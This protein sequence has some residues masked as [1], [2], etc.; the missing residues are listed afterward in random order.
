[1]IHN[2]EEQVIEYE[3]ATFEFLGTPIAFFP[4]FFHPDPTVKRKS[5]FLVPSVGFS[6]DLG[7]SVTLP[8]F[9]VIAPNADIT[10]TP[11]AY[12]RQGLLLDGEWRHRTEHG[13]YFVSAGGIL[14]A[15][16]TQFTKPGN[17]N[18]RGYVSSGGQFQLGSQ[19]VFGWNGA[20]VTDDSFLRKYEIN[21]DS[22][23]VSETYLV[24]QGDRNYFDAR[25]QHFRDLSRAGDSPGQPLIHPVVDH[26]VIFGHAVFGGEL[27]IDTNIT[28]LTRDVGPD[29][30]RAS[31]D[32]HWS[33]TFTD[34]FGQQFTPFFSVR[35][36]V[37]QVNAVLD[38]VTAIAG[39][40]ETITRGMA[41]AGFEY[42]YPFISLHSWGQQILEPIVQIIIR[43][44]EQNAGRI[45]NEDA[46]SLVFDDT[47]LFDRNKFSGYDRIEGGS[48]ANIGVRYTLQT[49][50]G[51]HARVVVGQ[52]FQLGGRNPFA[53]G[54]GLDSAR[55]DFVGGIY[56]E[57]TN[58]LGLYSQFRVDSDSYQVN[59]QEFG[60]RVNHNGGNA[61]ISYMRVRDETGVG[62]NREEVLGS[63]LVPVLPEWNLFGS[64]RY[65]IAG[66]Q[67]ISRSLG[68]GYVCDCFSASIE[69]K[70]SFYANRDIQPNRS[71]MFRFFFKS[72]GG[73]QVGSSILDNK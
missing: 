70:E 50:N 56:L 63:A 30:T 71:V 40:R 21:S 67:N 4:Y 45:S 7:A 2:Q 27:G 65:D 37:S 72:L 16:P 41:T 33:R 28:S 61:R 48:R 55:S 11:T 25:V 66:A 34:R 32:V 17:R 46:L 13:Q 64:Y 20:V 52:S 60:A 43:P 68:F 9:W 6:S 12:S 54:T 10:L 69:F 29:S 58:Y 36:D 19:W 31:V 38:P 62:M 8:Y 18:F 23:I 15:D 51:G 44:N 57:P 24:G 47:I 3:N 22:V 73:A 5:G 26:N 49:N 1:M 59:R 35:G 39:P 42:R 14:Q 53:V